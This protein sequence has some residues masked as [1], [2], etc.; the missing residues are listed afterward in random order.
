MILQITAIFFLMRR[1]G[2]LAL[3]KG[4]KIIPWKLYTASAWILAEF[5]GWIL[6]ASLFGNTNFVG[7]FSVGLFGAFG[8]YLI[9]RSILEKKPDQID[10]DINKIGVDDL[11]PPSNR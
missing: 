5:A 6:G 7:I 1:N 10:E 4:L 2:A 9:V 11:Q 3:R 8:G